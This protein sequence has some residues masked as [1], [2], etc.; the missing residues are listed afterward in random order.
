MKTHATP[1]FATSLILTLGATACVDASSDAFEDELLEADALEGEDEL[2]LDNDQDD[3]DEPM[4]EPAEPDAPEPD[5]QPDSRPDSRPDSLM[6][7]L[8]PTEIIDGFTI[9]S[10]R[11]VMISNSSGTG[12]ICSGTLLRN[13]VV[14]TARHCVTTNYTING[15]VAAA[16]ALTVTQ[17]GPGATLGSTINVSAVATMNTQDI[18]LLRLSSVFSIDGSPLG[19]S[20]QI[21]A[22]N[23]ANVVGTN[24]LCQGYGRNSCAGG[25]GTLRGGLVHVDDDN[26]GM[27]EYAPIN[28]NTWIQYKG[29]SGSSCRQSA[30]YTPN[31]NKILGVLSTAGCGWIATETGPQLYRSWVIDQMNTWAGDFADDFSNWGF[32]TIDEPAGMLAGPSNWNRAGGV[33]T[34]NSN[35]YTNTTDHE[36]TRYVSTLQVASDSIVTVTVSSADNDAAGLVLRYRD[37]TH[38]YRLSFDEQRRYARIVRRSGNSWTVIAEDTNFDIDWSTSPELSFYAVGTLLIGLVDGQIAVFGTDD[39][40]IAG[41]T[42]GRAGIYTW[43]LTGAT[44]DDFEI[45]RI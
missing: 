45:D 27:L 38:Y 35:A 33:L 30:F 42:A 24:V 2:E 7:E 15:P 44:F 29:D 3:D 26:A 37:D 32:Y 5:S 43:G 6:E 18:A 31:L 22:T 17:D 1:L 10:D 41:Y 9:D 8:D 40:P 34:E 16:N 39:D 23:Q 14:L 21:L 20:T 13:D 19:Q 25:A 28:G 36:G 11:D 4:G 12:G